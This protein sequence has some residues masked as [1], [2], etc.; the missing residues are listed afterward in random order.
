MSRPPLAGRLAGWLQPRSPEQQT[1]AAAWPC[2]V[3]T[4]S[5]LTL[6][7]PLTLTLTM[8]LALT[9]ILTLALALALDCC[10]LALIPTPAGQEQP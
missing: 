4:I 10:P 8:A 6:V 2:G 5:T 3:W 1:P 7:S 9:L